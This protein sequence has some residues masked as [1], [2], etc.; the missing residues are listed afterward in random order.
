MSRQQCSPTLTAP[1][2]DVNE[3][4]EPWSDRR[5]YNSEYIPE[6]LCSVHL[7]SGVQDDVLDA[8]VRVAALNENLE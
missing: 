7:A 5:S 8:A 3:R 1:Y 4:W 6:S 2:V